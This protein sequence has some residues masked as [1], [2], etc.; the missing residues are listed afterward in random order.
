MGC[1]LKIHISLGDAVGLG[2]GD[3]TDVGTVVGVIG[4]MVHIKFRK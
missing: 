4:K 3:T 2:G 1:G